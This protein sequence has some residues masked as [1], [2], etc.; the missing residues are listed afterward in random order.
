[1]NVK[2]VMETL[3]NLRAINDVKI[4]EALKAGLVKSSAYVLDQLKKNTPVDTGN[5]KK[6]ARSKVYPSAYMSLIG[7]DEAIAH[8][9]TWVEHGHHTVNGKWVKGQFF[10]QRTKLETERGVNEIFQDAIRIALK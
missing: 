9:A 1:M 2:G 6:S 5:L 4:P 8:Y 7:P 10:I 3:I